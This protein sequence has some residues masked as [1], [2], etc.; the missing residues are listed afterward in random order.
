MLI[1]NSTLSLTLQPH[2]SPREVEV[3]DGHMGAYRKTM[4]ETC[5]SHAWFRE[6]QCSSGVA[7]SFWLAI[8]LWAVFKSSSQ[9]MFSLNRANLISG[10]FVL[11]SYLLHSYI[12]MFLLWQV[13][14][15]VFHLF[16]QVSQLHL[17]G[18]MPVSLSLWA[19]CPFHGMFL[20]MSVPW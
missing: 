11:T 14:F 6:D 10:T 7:A 16:S 12:W 19:G 8:V 4:R 3:T 9:V 18:E 5:L 20:L 17:M 1:P 15:I 13:Y 2:S